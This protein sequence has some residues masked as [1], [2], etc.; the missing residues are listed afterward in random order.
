MFTVSKDKTVI[1]LEITIQLAS[2]SDLKEFENAKNGF[3]P[4]AYRRNAAL[5]TP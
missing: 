5:L 1:C 3:S 4:R 2:A